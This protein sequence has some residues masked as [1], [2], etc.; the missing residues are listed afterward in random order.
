LG[1]RELKTLEIEL[2]DQSRNLPRQDFTSPTDFGEEAV[3][4][5]WPA[6]Y[7]KEHK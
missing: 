5:P 4:S 3:L 2:N 6:D 1:F 7:F